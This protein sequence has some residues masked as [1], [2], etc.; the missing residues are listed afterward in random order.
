[1]TATTTTGIRS[2]GIAV[3]RA[4]ALLVLLWAPLALAQGNG[5]TWER[6]GQAGIVK[7]GDRYVPEYPKDVAALDAKV[8]KLQ[9]FMMP[10]EVGATQKRFLLSAQP[11]DCG[12]CVPSG[13]EG[14]VE[15]QAKTPVKYGLDPIYVTG[16]FVLVRD[17]AS[18]LF[19]RLTDATISDK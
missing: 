5:L 15:V 17:D 19:Y 10:L 14:L 3:T 2:T 4:V 1:M 8:V 18:G 6:L 12:Y 16:K 11:S 13:P 9:G 7:K